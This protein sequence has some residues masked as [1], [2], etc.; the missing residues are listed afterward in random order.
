MIL[1]IGFDLVEIERIQRIYQR[2]AQGLVKRLL[3]TVEKEQ[4]AMFEGDRRRVEWL[5]GRFAAKEAASKALGTGIGKYLSLH[6]IEIYPDPNGRPA[7]RVIN[8]DMRTFLTNCR[9]HLT[10]THNISTVGAL[11]IIEE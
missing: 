1:G 5:A 10:I 3:S 7:L 4:F 9:L 6:D 11:V 8:S 2:N